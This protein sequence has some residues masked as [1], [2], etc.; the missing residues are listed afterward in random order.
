MDKKYTDI[1]FD[2]NPSYRILNCHLWWPGG[3][4]RS[5]VGGKTVKPMEPLWIFPLHLPFFSRFDLRFPCSILNPC[6]RKNSAFHNWFYTL[7]F[8]QTGAGSCTRRWAILVTC[9]V[10]ACGALCF[11]RFFPPNGAQLVR[12]LDLAA[13]CGGASH[14]LHPT[15]GRN[16]SWEALKNGI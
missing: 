3:K 1:L 6:P 9:L 4:A 13:E 7:A 5:M 11:S 10:L 8:H 14:G 15:S 2:E 16:V 12:L